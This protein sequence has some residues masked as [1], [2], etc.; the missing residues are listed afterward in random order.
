[1]SFEETLAAH[2]QAKERRLSA[3]FTSLD[4]LTSD[5]LYRVIHHIEIRLKA[6]AEAEATVTRRTGTGKS[7]SAPDKTL[8]A[9]A[10]PDASAEL[11]NRKAILRVVA[12]TP[13]MTTGGIVRAVQKF[14]PEAM[15][16]S[17]GSEVKRMKDEELLVKTG[18]TDKGYAK[19]G[20]G[21]K[22]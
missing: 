11:S 22:A 4:G 7:A 18:Q 14:K 21:P 6:E 17:I 15:K 12:E 9:K 20:L 1:M 3:V 2:K 19:Y 13:G 16:D 5:D 10:K 8:P